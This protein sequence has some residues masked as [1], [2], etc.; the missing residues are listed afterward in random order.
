M[1]K[2]WICIATAVLIS[3]LAIRCATTQKEDVLPQD[4]PSM[5]AL[6]DNHF[7]KLRQ[8]QAYHVREQLGSRPVVDA[9]YRIH[10]TKTHQE[11][12]PSTGLKGA[13]EPSS[14][15]TSTTFTDD[16]SDVNTPATLDHS[17]PEIDVKG[18]TETAENTGSGDDDINIHEVDL[19]DYTR[20]SNNEIQGLFPR[21]PNPDLLMYV[22]PHLAGPEAVP[23]PGYATTFPMYEQVEYAMPGEVPTG[24]SGKAH[25]KD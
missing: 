9:P 25:V 23:V 18:L 4:G 7:D 2:R 19:S 3:P 10:N 5:R 6:Y 14:M 13:T 24:F 20:K 22:F 12:S 1:P 17:A 8:H 15:D 16:D 21:L 11:D